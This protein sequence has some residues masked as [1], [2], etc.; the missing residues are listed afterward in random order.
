MRP[1]N[2]GPF[3]RR[4]HPYA[5]D[6]AR[7]AIRLGCG[8]LSSCA[9]PLSRHDLLGKWNASPEI[10]DFFQSIEFRDDGTGTLQS[11][12]GHALCL[13]VDYRWDL[14][15][16]G[17]LAFRFQNTERTPWPTYTPAPGLS[18]HEVRCELEVGEFPLRVPAVVGTITYRRRLRFDESPLPKDA[19]KYHEGSLFFPVVNQID[20]RQF[21]VFYSRPEQSDVLPDQRPAP[22]DWRDALQA[23]RHLK[24]ARFPG[25]SNEMFQGQQWI[26][27]VA[28]GLFL[29]EACVSGGGRA[30]VDRIVWYQPGT[31]TNPIGQLSVSG[32]TALA[33]TI[34]DRLVGEVAC[35][36]ERIE[37]IEPDAVLVA[38][39]APESLWRSRFERPDGAPLATRSPA[40]PTLEEFGSDLDLS[41]DCS[42]VGRLLLIGAGI[43]ALDRD[44]AKKRTSK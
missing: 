14:D 25:P 41:A 28:D 4:G 6:E 19:A 3:P 38:R 12:G 43:L 10:D 11:A 32:A 8:Q 44:T 17:R 37:L 34:G 7:V 1:T 15:Q 9:M 31:T 13:A 42:E 33:L 26:R 21:L 35:Q 5:E 18:R 24:F 2:A 20:P 16:Q 29:L 27:V 22:V 30:P 39:E 36:G 23:C 40:I